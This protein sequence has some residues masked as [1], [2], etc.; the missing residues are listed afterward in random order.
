M[1]AVARIS[2]LTTARAPRSVS[3]LLLFAVL[4]SAASARAQTDEAPP[5]PPSE[6]P[7]SEAP[8]SEAPPSEAPP[9]TSAEP[10]GDATA[11][12]NAPADSSTPEPG[13][14][15][16]IAA[17]PAEVTIAGTRVAK[18]PGSAHIVNNKKLERQEYDDAQAILQTV[19]GVYVRTEDGV[20]L[21]PNI[22]L[23]GTNPNRSSK[24]ALMEDGVPF[25]PA[26]Y[27]AP[28]AYYFPLMQRMYQVRVI[29]GPATIVYGPQTVG[30]AI[31][32]VTRP[33]PAAPSGKVDLAV[34]QYGYGKLH[35]WYGTSNES[36]GFL[37]EA[38]HLR[39]DGFKELPDGSDTGSYRNEFMLKA[40]HGFD[41]T[42]ALRHDIQL[43]AT[44]SE[45][46]SHETYLGTTDEDFRAAPLSRYA[47]SQ[48]DRMR[49]NRTALALTHVVEPT[50][51]MKLTTTA[52]RNDFQRVWNRLKGVRG[53]GSD[54]GLFDVLANPDASEQNRHVVA[55]LSGREDSTGV[56]DV[57]LHGPNDR[58]FVSQGIQTVVSFEPVTGPISHRIEY[59][60]RLHY[61]RV[62]RRQSESG[63]LMLGGRMIPEGTP[64]IVTEFNEA[65]TESAALHV[66]DAM[67]WK[68]LTLTPG[69]RFEFWHASGTNKVT[70]GDDGGTGQVVLPGVG[71]YWSIIDELGL[72]A[73]AYRG[74]SPPVPPMPRNDPTPQDERGMKNPELSWNYEAGAR[75]TQDR[76]RVELIGFYNDYSNLTDVCTQS[77]GCLDQNLDRQFDA[78]RAKIYGLEAYAEHEPELGV[79]HFPMNVAY[80]LTFAEFLDR[81]DSSDPMWGSVL[82]G[83]ELPYVPRHQLNATAGV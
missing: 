40:G 31:D 14:D 48:M 67:T 9:A 47:A 55:V 83:D 13:G 10:P 42:S 64:V 49:W 65:S 39:N 60:V 58:E 78:G 16:G 1:A 75:F 56:N 62:E 63:Y 76:A 71:A 46:D 23:R 7:P 69:V 12:P 79:V 28:A 52:Y 6:A 37:V 80:T 15:T 43:K 34:G 70:N 81:F 25:G 38:V 35:A 61:D 5:P 44:Y 22:G 4:S 73:G 54:G 33:I 68:T 57:L 66:I 45:E 59:G 26:P 24:V 29:K 74:F 53:V 50:R 19:P 32:F 21:R 30:G 20:G 8:P 27:S 18:T 77:S 41:P 3:S 51:K 72:L 17:E 2:D 82:P 11:E 36:D